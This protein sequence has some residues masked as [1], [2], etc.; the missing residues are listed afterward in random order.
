M[1]T[2]EYQPVPDKN[3]CQY[4]APSEEAA[5]IIPNSLERCGSGF[6]HNHTVE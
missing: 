5:R 6:E 3:W 2:F 1:L 4:M